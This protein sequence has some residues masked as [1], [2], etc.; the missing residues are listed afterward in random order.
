MLDILLK[1]CSLVSLIMVFIASYKTIGYLYWF[2]VRKKKCR[3]RLTRN[4]L[5]EVAL[6][7]LSFTMVSFAKD[8]YMEAVEEITVEIMENHEDELKEGFSWDELLENYLRFYF[9][10][11]IKEKSPDLENDGIRKKY[12]K[13]FYAERNFNSFTFPEVQSCIS[14]FRDTANLPGS[15]RTYQQVDE[16]LRKQM[17]LPLTME[18]FLVRANLLGEES[19]SNMLYQV[20]RT[21]DNAL[22]LCPEYIK[23]QL[24]Y[25]AIAVPL[26]ELS[27][28]KYDEDT[29][30]PKIQIEY[31][32]AEVYFWLFEHCVFEGDSKEIRLHLLLSTES[33]LKNALLENNQN[34]DD[35]DFFNEYPYYTFYLA[36]V[37]YNLIRYF[38]LEGMDV[39]QECK[40][41]ANIFLENVGYY[42]GTTNLDKEKESCLAMI[43]VL[44]SAFSNS[45]AEE[46]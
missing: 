21:A 33:I 19:D 40:K 39:I 22:R 7:V 29:E 4:L 32:I 35:Q 14:M 38:G 15:T 31:N 11:N 18:S 25:S 46:E 10:E 37:Q 8:Y 45:Q 24:V 3:K 2:F 17:S 27:L 12:L 41:N 5:I 23:Q 9:I 30:V 34:L 16:E 43:S 1:V 42:E 36:K 13:E 28:M 44:E 6:L 26:Y 20:G